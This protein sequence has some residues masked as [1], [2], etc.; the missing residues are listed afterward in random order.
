MLIRQGLRKLGPVGRA[1]FGVCMAG[2]DSGFEVTGVSSVGDGPT[3]TE[4][5]AGCDTFRVCLGVGHLD[6]VA[7]EV[8][9]A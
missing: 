2:S 7:R 4:L 1:N 5:I 9:R 8:L 6:V 3:F